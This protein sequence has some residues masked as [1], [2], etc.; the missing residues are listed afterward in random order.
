MGTWKKIAEAF[1]RARE[2]HPNRNP[3]KGR[4]LE[5]GSLE[6]TQKA[7]SP[8]DDAQFAPSRREDPEVEEAY[9]RGIDQGREINRAIINA[10]IHRGGSTPEERETWRHWGEARTTDENLKQN[11]SDE[12]DK[13]FAERKARV[14]KWYGDDYP[15]DMAEEGA[16]AFEKQLWEYV[17]ELK[18]KG[19]S[20]QDILN[21]IK[22]NN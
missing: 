2:L 5:D 10:S 22:G 12:W 3:L 8:L 20:A 14:K 19:V 1:G 7:D 17:D 6:L 13:A 4:V 18:A 16:N 11:V 15:Q 21:R 9:L